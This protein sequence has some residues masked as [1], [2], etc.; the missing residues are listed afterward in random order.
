M[1]FNILLYLIINLAIAFRCYFQKISWHVLL[2]QII[3]AYFIEVNHMLLCS[4][5]ICVDVIVFVSS[6]FDRLCTILFVA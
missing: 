4:G 5:L 1:T 3:S 6:L 2:V